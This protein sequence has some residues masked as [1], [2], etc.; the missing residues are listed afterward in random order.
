[1]KIKLK[2]SL[3]LI[4][5]HKNTKLSVDMAIE[6]NEEDKNLITGEVL[7]SNSPNVTKGETVI[8]G[9]YALLT[10]ALQ[11][12]DYHVLEVDD[13]LGTCDYKENV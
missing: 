5:K 12:E 7:E 8:F 13:V 11:G 6:E 9:R 4:R 1:M 2:N 3:L 10:L